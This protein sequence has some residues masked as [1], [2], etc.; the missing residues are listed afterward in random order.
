MATPGFILGDDGRGARARGGLHPQPCLGSVAVVGWTTAIP[1][2]H[3]CGEVQHPAAG[4]RIYYDFNEPSSYFKT[5]ERALSLL[6]DVP[7]IQWRILMNLAHAFARLN[8]TQYRDESTIQR[9]KILVL[10]ISYTAFPNGEAPYA[11][12]T[13]TVTFAY[14]GL[15]RRCTAVAERWPEL[16]K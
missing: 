7:I 16:A 10:T 12:E 6:Y 1:G 14:E 9:P 8:N 15:T 2:E 3:G 13:G 5:V 11:D 4:I